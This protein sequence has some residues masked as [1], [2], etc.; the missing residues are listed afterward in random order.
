MK[1]KADWLWSEFA[2]LFSHYISGKM[3]KQA[4][5]DAWAA[6]LKEKGVT[7]EQ[8]AEKHGGRI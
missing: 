2:R 6:T 5:E 8:F 3:T 7:Q 1:P 4:F